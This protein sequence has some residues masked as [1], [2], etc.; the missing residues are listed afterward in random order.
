M[1]GPVMQPH[2]LPLGRIGTPADI[3]NACLFLASAA[4]SYIT[5]QLIAVDGGFSLS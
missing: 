2:R 3:A 5:G 4:S 1:T